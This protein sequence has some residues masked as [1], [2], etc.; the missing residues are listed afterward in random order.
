MKKLD[1]GRL[2]CNYLAGLW[3]GMVALALAA[4]RN[5][6][7]ERFGA[8][9]GRT[10]WHGSIVI[11]SMAFV[12]GIASWSV[13]RRRIWGYYLSL[14]ISVYLMVNSAYDFFAL[15]F[16]GPR[17]WFPGILFFLGTVALVWL[18]SP[19]LRSQFSLAVHKAKAA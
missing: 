14:A 1:A 2:G 18:V 13:F 6:V 10:E 17:H 11:L 5:L 16:N 3:L 9:F 12:C 19:A 7:L 8:A 15:P 4:Q